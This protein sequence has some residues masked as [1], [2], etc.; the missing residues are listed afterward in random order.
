MV[1]S[2]SRILRVGKRRHALA[3]ALAAAYGVAPPLAQ[4]NPGGAVVVHGQASMQTQG[5][6]LTVTNTPGAIINWQQFSIGAGETTYFQQQNAASTVLNRVQTQNPA[7]RSQIDGTLGSNGRVFLINPN[8]VV[9]GPGSVIDTQG[10][11]AS[12]LSLNDD[13]FKAGKFRFAR[14]GAAGDIQVQGRISSG[15]GDVY[16]IAPNVGTDGNAVIRSEGGN[17]VLAAGE[18]VEITG[19]NLNDI[20]FEVQNQGNGVINLGRLEGGAVGVFAGTLKHSGVVQAQTL[21]REGGRLVLKAQGDV[22]VAADS[23]ARADGLTVGGTVTLASQSGHV[24]VD[25][26]AQI[27]ASATAASPATQ[28][29]TVGGSIAVSADAGFVALEAGSRLSAD[30]GRGGDIQVSAARLVQDGAV[31]ADGSSSMGG[32]IRLQADSRLIQG[33]SATASAQGVLRGGDIQV[34]VDAAPDG[35]GHLFSSATL[36]ASAGSG[37]GG[38]ITVTGRDVTLAAAQVRADGDAGGGTIRVGG[39]RAGA[40]ATMD[41]ARNLTVSASTAL[42]ASARVDGDGGSI[43]T[44]AD[45]DNRFAGS[46]TAR[47][48]AQGGNGGTLEVSARQQV[49]FGG[50]A[51]AGAPMG[52][53]GHFLLDPKNILIQTPVFVPGV[54]VELLD[55]NPGTGDLFGQSLQVLGNGN[56]LVFDSNDDFAATNA[57]AIYLFDGLTGALISN[58]RGSAANDRIGSSGVVRNLSGGNVLVS[59]PFWNGS[60]GALTPFGMAA[61]VSGA[62]SSTNSL[63]GA[64]TGDQIGSSGITAMSG[65]KLAIFS[66]NWNSGAGAITWAD[67][68]TGIT[69]VVSSA[70]SLVGAMANDRVGNS[71][72]SSIGSSRY[73]V[74]TSAWNNNAGA[75][76]WI[77]PGSP[78][79]GV[80]GAANSLVGAVPGDQIGSGGIY[81]IL[82]GK[83]TIFS[84]NWSGTRG[85]V[86]FMDQASGLVGI[87][88]AANSLVGT[89]PGDRVGNGYW[90]YVGGKIAILSPDWANGPTATAAGAITWFDSAS[91]VTGAVSAANSLVGS[92]ANDRVGDTG[93]EYIDGTRYL[94]VNTRWNN[95][96]G[97]VT[98]VD[99]NAP[100]IGVISTNNSLVGSA[101]G[102]EVGSGW[103]EDFGFGKIAVFSPDWNAA[104]GA[105]SW[106]GTTTGGNGVVDATNSLVGTN[107]GDRVGGFSQYSYLSGSRVAILSEDWANTPAAPQAGAVTWVDAS[108]GLVGAVG[109]GNSLVGSQSN[110]RVGSDGITWL[111]GTH[112]A[113]VSPQWNGSRGA[114]TWVDSSSPVTGVV[115]GA[116]SLVGS[117]V[118]DRVGNEG[119]YSVGSKSLVF[120]RNWDNGKGAVSWLDNTSGGSGIVD[121]TNSLVGSTAGDQVGGFADFEYVGSK[122]AILSPNW[123]NGLAGAAGAITWADPSVGVVGVVA[124]GNSLVGVATNDRVGNNGIDYLDGTHYLVRTPNWNTGMGAVTWIDSNAAPVGAVGAANSLVG[125]IAGD[126]VGSSGVQNLFNGQSI[127]FSPAWHANKGAVTWLDHATGVVG[128]VDASNSLVGSTSGTTATGDRIGALGYQNLGNMI[129]LR[130]PNWNN[131]AAAL[132]GAVTFVDPLGGIT[133][134]VSAANSLVG[135]QA[136]DR[137]GNASLASLSNGNYYLLSSSWNGNAGAVTFVNPNAAPLL[138]SV[139]AGNSLVGASAGDQVGGSGVQNLFNGKALVL[140]PG[141]NGGMGAVTWFDTVNGTSGTVG[142]ANS[143]VGSTAGDAVGSSGRTNAGNWIGIRSPNWDNG[144]ITDAGA[145]TWADAFNGITGAVSAANSLVGAAASDRV[146]TSGADFLSSTRSAVRTT[147]WGGGAG[148][149]T[150]IDHA[151]PTVGVVTPLNSLVGSAPGDQVGSG[152][153]S[154]GNGYVLLRSTSWSGNRG[155]VTWV[156]VGAPLTGVVSSANSLVGANPNDFV[157]SSG[158]SFMS[159]GNYYVRSTNFGGNAGAVS[160]G[161]AAGGISGVVSAANSLVG[162]NANDGYG[163]TVQEISGSRLLVRAS[164]ADSGGLSNNGRVHI[165][166]GGAGGGGGPGGPLGGQAFSDNLASLITISPAQLTAI[167]NT[168]TAVSLQANN[169]ITLD[170]L[171]DIIV[172]NPSGTGG[173]LTLQ[174]GR[175][176]YLHSNIVTDGGDLDVIANELAS[177]GVLTSHRDPGLAEIVMANGTRLDAGAGAVKL[178]LRDGAGRTGLQAAALGIQMRSI[179]AGTLLARSDTGAVLIGAEAATAPS[180]I[181]VLG[182]ASIIAK[183]SVSLLGGSAGAQA[184]L[185]ADGQITI[186]SPDPLVDPAPILTLTNAGSSARIVNPPGTFP[187]ILSGSQCIGCTVVSDFEITGANGSIIDVI[188]SSLLTLQDNFPDVFKRQSADEDD[189]IGI[190]AGETCQ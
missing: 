54:S 45:G 35:D 103:F 90:D 24:T 113:V 77:D 58:L 185:S 171:S 108:V 149:V 165:Y 147:G 176:I 2:G 7:L 37:V 158:V 15:N 92:Q 173:K 119:V 41:N 3:I 111:D 42:Q 97:A 19:R 87:V 146:G 130:A 182:N 46:M 100:P 156:D 151:A 99:S 154:Y 34:R 47:G 177:N 1:H 116:N 43:T 164:N 73:Y 17:V 190:D 107:D 140:S 26:G 23:Q 188:T 104:K 118:N 10:F 102:D 33:A 114:V 145:I 125:D 127:V 27:S 167:L 22:H 76:T 110:D 55:P 65:G 12:T 148:A 143:L 105:V 59:S 9:F 71:G 133:G 60:A 21:A 159:N 39:G 30:G 180:E 51:D 4:A 172:N 138:G 112:V 70:N 63:V 168:G 86:T 83:W 84:P 48:G 94:I 150:W 85:A 25:G 132:A 183:T 11:V 144:L 66:P 115:S 53:G 169:D 32:T 153:F 181:V 163:G 175:S 16:L 179:S 120:S 74:A 5:N 29:S 189:E 57:G 62:L 141:W 184:L 78:V 31:H 139:G 91:I 79:V 142:A 89:D 95:D 38:A 157:G 174:A 128:V 101:P 82:G 155:A 6:R 68:G 117:A 122:I 187:L 98:W 129:V 50:N 152:G 121:A 137:V 56:I 61:G 93:F 135:T 75:V 40:D 88:G 126:Q 8:G 28:A 72:L 162:Q 136:N 64:S 67:G 166:S 52:Q 134:V 131:G 14:D 160:V 186:A 44:W 81:N 18:M 20:S 106:I 170:V 178:L 49:Q 80:M 109:A 96:T 123:S 69:G 36:D 13:D 161:A 124:A